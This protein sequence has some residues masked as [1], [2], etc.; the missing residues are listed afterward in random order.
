MTNLT[1][2]ALAGFFPKIIVTAKQSIAGSRF[3]LAKT[4]SNIKQADVLRRHQGAAQTIRL[5]RIVVTKAH[6]PV[7]NSTAT[8]HWRKRRTI[9]EAGIRFKKQKQKTEHASL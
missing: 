1:K 7:Q 5:T 6:L 3:E 4:A 9:P 2:I 8:K